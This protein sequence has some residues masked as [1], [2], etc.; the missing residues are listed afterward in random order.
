[1]LESISADLSRIGSEHVRISF[2]ADAFGGKIR[3]NV[4]HEWRSLHHN[5]KVA[6]AAADISLAQTSQ[7]IGLTDHI[8]GL[9]RACNFSF[10]GNL[11]DPGRITASLWT[12]AAAITWRNRTAEA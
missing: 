2:D 11:A 5:W 6:G 1:D 9:L 12:E 8:G 10:R 7:A 4:S 3:G